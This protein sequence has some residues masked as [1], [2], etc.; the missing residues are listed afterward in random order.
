MGTSYLNLHRLEEAETA[1]RAAIAAS[2]SLMFPHASLA[3]IL[4]LHGKI[5]E[6][7]EEA[8]VARALATTPGDLQ[9]I[10]ELLRTLESRLP[11]APSR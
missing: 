9:Q 8:R 4:Y 6:A 1:Y 2:P 3:M 11:H 10:D 5:P 7:M